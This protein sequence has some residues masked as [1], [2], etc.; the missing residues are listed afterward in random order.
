MRISDTYDAFSSSPTSSP[1]ADHRN[2]SNTT[3]QQQKPQPLS[4]IAQQAYDR[5]GV[6]DPIKL[7]L[8]VRGIFITREDAAALPHRITP[9]GCAEGKTS[10]CH[11]QRASIT[12]NAPARQQA[13]TSTPT[14]PRAS[15]VTA[16]PSVGAFSSSPR[17]DI[18]AIPS[19]HEKWSESETRLLIKLRAERVGFKYIVVRH[20]HP[21]R[22]KSSRYALLSRLTY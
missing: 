2:N 9:D 16:A 3:T 7:D 11:Y 8:M 20:P 6:L 22:C 5:Y 19:D 18:S 17:T 12:S 14:V 1:T 4:A 13:L 10:V 21:A 15:Q